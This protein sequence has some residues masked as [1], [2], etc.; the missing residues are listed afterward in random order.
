MINFRGLYWGNIIELS[1]L[2]HLDIGGSGS[3]A[4]WSAWTTCYGE[5]KKTRQRECR[6]G[7]VA[8]TRTVQLV[9]EDC[10]GAGCAG[11]LCY[12]D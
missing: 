4:P 9:T 11:T 6:N 2:S 3:W 1:S 10:Y 8:C 7:G 12:F 5:E